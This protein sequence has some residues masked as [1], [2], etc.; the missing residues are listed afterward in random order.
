MDVKV[1]EGTS[2]SAGVTG[3]APPDHKDRWRDHTSHPALENPGVLPEEAAGEAAGGGSGGRD[4]CSHRRMRV[5]AS[6]LVGCCHMTV[7]RLDRFTAA[8]DEAN[9]HI[10]CSRREK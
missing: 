10:C 7:T 2:T 9:R 4:G 5:D 8:R 1:L 6:Q 3:S